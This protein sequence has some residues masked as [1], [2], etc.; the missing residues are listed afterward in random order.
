VQRGKSTCLSAQYNVVLQKLDR[1]AGN[2]MNAAEMLYKSV[3]MAGYTGKGFV[4]DV[5][6]P[7]QR[8]SFEGWINQLRSVNQTNMYTVKPA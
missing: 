7:A 3:E 5:R 1:D 6:L 8:E 4:E 2:Q